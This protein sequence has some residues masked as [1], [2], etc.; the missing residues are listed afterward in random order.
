MTG[1][2]ITAFHANSGVAA[3]VMASVLIGAALAVLL[4]W[5]VWA[6]RTAY[7]GW[8]ENRINERQFLGVIVRFLAMYVVLTYFLLS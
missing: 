6:A 7:V 1:A 4:V 8:T 3:S 2:Q 5:G